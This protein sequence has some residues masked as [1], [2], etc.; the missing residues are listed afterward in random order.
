MLIAQPVEGSAR[1]AVFLGVSQGPVIPFAFYRSGAW[2]NE[3]R[4]TYDLGRED[5]P[6]KV[7]QLLIEELGDAGRLP[8]HWWFLPFGGE[9]REIAVS[10]VVWLDT[11]CNK[12]W[13]ISTELPLTEP[14]CYQCCPDPK[15]GLVSNLPVF[16]RPFERIDPGSEQAKDLLSEVRAK[17][18]ELEAESI[19]LFLSKFNPIEGRLRFEGHPI[20]EQARQGAPFEGIE[21]WRGSLAAGRAL[22]RL[23]AVREYPKPENFHDAGCNS[24]THFSTWFL[25]STHGKL[26]ILDPRAD[27]SDCD[28]KSVQSITPIALFSLDGQDFVV[29]LGSGWDQDAYEIF[30]VG[31]DGVVLETS[32]LI[33]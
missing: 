18:E 32:T 17:W 16:E 1:E 10:E 7:R 15:L 30:S 29:T 31:P 9:Q 26:S 2:T 3:W 8:A 19:A 14:K 4:E 12:Y 24:V 27:L 21:L 5:G 11:H 22:Y 20:E 28:Y 13:A 6:R 25:E 23:E 33:N